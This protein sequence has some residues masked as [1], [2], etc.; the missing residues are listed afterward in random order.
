[1]RYMREQTSLIY[2]YKELL[3]LAQT[4]QRLKM[5]SNQCLLNFIKKITLKSALFC[6]FQSV[7]RPVNTLADV[8]KGSYIFRK[9]IRRRTWVR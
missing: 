5:V 1:M 9:Q 6:G 4:V 2:K 8:E 3:H 7:D